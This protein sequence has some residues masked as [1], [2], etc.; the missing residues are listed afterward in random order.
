MGQ[1]RPSPP[2][3]ARGWQGLGKMI[4]PIWL[5]SWGP[6]GT[7]LGTMRHCP[8]QDPESGTPFRGL[9]F[10]GLGALS[11]HQLAGFGGSPSP[12]LPAGAPIPLYAPRVWGLRLL[13]SPGL[14]SSHSPLV[15]ATT[16]CL[17]ASTP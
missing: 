7:E 17:G 10:S 6:C 9:P 15:G 5:R 3:M 13:K 11:L 16:V 8:S 1:V 2:L 4:E 12:K 14:G